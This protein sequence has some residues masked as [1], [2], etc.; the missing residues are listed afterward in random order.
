MGTGWRTEPRLASRR[1]RSVATANITGRWRRVGL[2]F[3]AYLSRKEFLLR[4][5]LDCAVLMTPGHAAWVQD[6]VDSHRG[7]CGRLRLYTLDLTTLAPDAP[8]TQLLS[9][10]HLALR[11]FDCCVLPVA[12][13]SLSWARTMLGNTESAWPVPLIAL[14]FDIAAPALLDLLSLGVADFVRAPACFDELRARLVSLHRQARPA[15]NMGDA[16]PSLPLAAGRPALAGSEGL[17][18][19][20]IDAR[21]TGKTVRESWRVYE[22]SPRVKRESPGAKSTGSASD[23]NVFDIVS[24]DEPFRE[25]KARI[26]DGFE[27]AYLRHA[28]VRYSGNVAQAARA[29]SKHRRAFWA[30]MRKH[31]IDAA[32]Y[33]NHAFSPEL[34]V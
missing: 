26:I 31:R 3:F 19:H 7:Q 2:L 29:S 14:T 16:I 5:T 34:L 25:A 32:H 21:A 18:T 12:T 15:A 28:L 4:E 13:A 24:V 33:R 6:W 10:A 30:L 9:R 27:Q 11:R 20:S 22:V 8:D 17:H 23:P 1:S